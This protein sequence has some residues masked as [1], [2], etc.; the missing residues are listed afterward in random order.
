[1]SPHGYIHTAGLLETYADPKDEEKKKA[2][3]A[4]GPPPPS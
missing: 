4:W 2:A 1:M 3:S